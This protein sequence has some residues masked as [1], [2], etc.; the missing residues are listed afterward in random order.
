MRYNVIELLGDSWTVGEPYRTI[1]EDI[2]LDEALEL[3]RENP[4]RREIM[5]ES[6]TIR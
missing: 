4:F 5:R 2:S 1:A 3:S 6:N